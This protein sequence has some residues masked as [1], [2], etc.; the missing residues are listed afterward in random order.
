MFLDCITNYTRC[1]SRYWHHT[2]NYW[3]SFHHFLNSPRFWKHSMSR[4]DSFLEKLQ[5]GQAVNLSSVTRVNWKKNSKCIDKRTCAMGALI[6]PKRCNTL[7]PN[8]LQVKGLWYQRVCVEL[9]KESLKD[10]LF[11]HLVWKSPA[12]HH[13]DVF[14]VQGVL[15]ITTI[16]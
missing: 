1:K 2:P 10:N 5:K 14:S 12:G 7:N 15:Y 3:D 13:R 11:F 4:G 8:F 16:I 6:G 9:G